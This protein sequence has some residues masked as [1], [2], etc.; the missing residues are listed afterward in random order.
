MEILAKNREADLETDVLVLGGGGAGL[1]AGLTAAGQ[2]SEGGGVLILEKM[3]RP[4]CNTARSG[5]MIPAAGTRFQR[6]AGIEEGPEDFAGDIFRKNRHQSDPGAT[7]VL[8][9]TAPRMVEWLVDEAGVRL[10]LED[11]FRYPGHSRCRMH[12][13]PDRTGYSL[14]HDLEMAVSRAGIDLVKGAAGQGLLVDEDGAVC[15]AVVRQGRETLRIRARRVI[16]ATN[17][18]G[19]NPVLIARHC[20][21]AAGGLYFGGEGSTGEAIGWGEELG[22]ATAFMDAFQGHATVAADQGTLITYAVVMEGGVLVDRDGR[23]FGDE[24][25]GY[26]EF[27]LKVL[28][29]PGKTAWA[30]YDHTVHERGM[31]FADYRDAAATG[32]FREAGSVTALAERTGMPAAALNGT[33]KDYAAAAR[34]ERPDAF[35][36]QDCREP[37]RPLVAVRVTGALLHTQGGLVVDEHARVLRPDGSRIPGLYA[38]GGVAAGISGHGAAGYLSGN[39]LLTALGYGWLAGRHAGSNHSEPNAQGEF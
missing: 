15:G 26:S 5:G 30:V 8:T 24:T 20:P 22:A 36:R 31:A 32:A 16:L 7:R 29:R 25:E 14:I 35:G 1:T 27:S 2:R 33:L 34:G 23:R 10:E 6:E 9:E 21:A 17:G 12:V 11:S 4:L 3:L 37:G 18:F 19:G 13:P 39:G 28:A 38:C